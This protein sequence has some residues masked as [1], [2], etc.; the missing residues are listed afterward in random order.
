ME[1]YNVTGMSCAACSARVEKAVKKVPGVTSCSVSL[2]TNSMGVE[3]TASPAAIISA[4]QEAGYG[5]SPK[6]DTAHKASDTNADLDAL[7]DHET[8][9]LKRRLIASLGFLL[10]LMYFS[11]GHM[12]WG[13]PLPHWFDGNHIAMGLVQLILAGI[14][15]V[16]NQKFFISGFKGLIH[17]A[18]NMDTLV[19]LGSMASYVWSTYALF[20]MTDA[21][22]HGNDA[23]VMHY[24]M[25]F[26]FES[27]A[28]ILTL[29]T[30]GKMLEARSK[31]KTTDALKSLMKLAP[32]TAT[33]VRDGAEVT[34]SIADVQKG[35]I[36]VVRPGENIPVDG[37]VLEG[38][39]AVN[40]S[41]LT[42]ESIP[43]D[44]A[45]G[46]RVSAA[47][48]NQS[49]FLRCEA[50]RVGEDTTLSQIIKMVSDAAATK[51]P[52]AKIADT[53]SGYFV[54]AVISIAVLT[55]IVWLLLGRELGY[56]LARGIS[57][58]VISCPCAL[59]LAT[60]VA[61]MVGNGLGAKNGILFKTAASLEAAG[62]TQIVALDKTGTITEGAPRVTD[63]LPAEG[64][65]ETELLTLAAALESRSE[66][67]L[68]KAVLAY[69]EAK[70]I[71]P[72]TVTDFAALP[73]NGLAAKLDDVDIF[74]GSTSFI[75]SKLSL[76]AALTQ[77]AEQLAAEGKTPLFFGGA[78]RLLGV[79]A[80]ADTIKADSPEA[81][82]QLQ[83]MGIRVVM[84]TGDNQRTADA[85]GRQAGVDEVIAGVLP[86]GKEAVIRQ[87]QAS[88]KVAMVGD[89]INDAPALTRADTG[90][91]IGAGT[92]VAIDAADVVL[93]NSRLSDVP[94]AIR[95]S[96]AALRNIHEN[97]FWAFIYN[98]IGIP[99]AA[100]LFIPFGLTLNPMF[101]AAAMSLSSFCVVSNA[102]RL[103]L[104]NLHSTKHGHKKASPAAVSAQ[105]AAE[106]N[107]PSDTEAPDGKMEDDPMKKTLNVEGMMCCHCEARVKKALEAIPGVSEAVASHTDGTAVVTLTKDV[108]DDVLKNAVEAQDYKVTGIQ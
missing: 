99:L 26:Y 53:V 1:Q 50:T 90:I 108:A 36:F 6:S 56:A 80:V 82:R 69:S 46:D 74:G 71:T 91:A 58:L 54:P 34:V 70:A 42:G 73:G 87:L 21:Q 83:N 4:V 30:V 20:A 101:G 43:V 89:G 13:W 61:I 9:K 64:V 40:E 19:A 47:T 24:M 94:A 16:I 17:G 14:V 86:D 93:M 44:K 8:P 103:N 45:A 12:M 52:I 7:A 37:V 65:S 78:G 76:P 72:P 55:T 84:L 22:L 68:A 29:I 102:L 96:R 3:G 33:L 97:L 85:I 31:G 23:L 35:D 106:N 75:Q 105:S 27:A 11:M 104:F 18:P 79:I 39:S 57:V 2:L 32:K 77:Q 38:V 28:M 59:G 88:G 60:P 41:A 66:H 25:E 92:D 62:R 15:M 107:T 51:A 48:T 95:L 10:V 98:I 100:G 63:L 67:P 81:I 5:A 49:G